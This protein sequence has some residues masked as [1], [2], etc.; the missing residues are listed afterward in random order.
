MT[1]L[2]KKAKAAEKT[3]NTKVAISLYKK[4][5]RE[6]KSNRAAWVRLASLFSIQKETESAIICY[7]RALSLQEDAIILFNLAGELYK[8][9][10]NDNAIVNLKRALEL[11]NDFFRAA[12]LLG[13]IYESQESFD[14]A[15]VAFRRALSLNRSSR[16]AALGLIVSLTETDQNQEAYTIAQHYLKAQPNDEALLNLNAALLMKLGRYRESFDQLKQ[17]TSTNQ[18]YTSFDDHLK[19]AKQ[20][21]DQETIEFFETANQRRKERT[22]RLKQKI[23]ERKQKQQKTLTKED[24]TEDTKDLLDLSLLHL[25]S[26]E[27]D[28]ALA[29]LVEA[30]KFA[31]KKISDQ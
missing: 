19:K 29:F 16:L 10:D 8:N 24:I 23:E 15:V 25:F 1:E 4:V 30:K 20:E 5:L 26:G 18:K 14:D 3:G 2:L 12:L 31:D 22:E 27:K 7:R 11:Q 13:Y 17:V 28:K 21:R 6:D 9:K